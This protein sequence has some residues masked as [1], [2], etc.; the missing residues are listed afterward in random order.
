MPRSKSKR[1]TSSQGKA[2]QRDKVVGREAGRS[3]GRGGSA[4]N[5][6]RKPQRSDNRQARRG[7]HPDR[8][9]A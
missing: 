2:G 7:D 5:A 8:E 9:E 6:D 4:G 1:P 3:G